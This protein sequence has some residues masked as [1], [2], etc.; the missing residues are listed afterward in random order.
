VNEIPSSIKA[1]SEPQVN[2][3]PPEV[4]ARRA[5][6][7]QRSAVFFVFVLFLAALG[8][9]VYWAGSQEAAAKDDLQAAQDRGAELAAQIAQYDY[10]VA[11]QLELLNAENAK[12]YVGSTEIDYVTLINGMIEALPDG[13]TFD[14]L[15]WTVMSVDS[16]DP[17]VTVLDPFTVPDL[18]S[19]VI[20]GGLPFYVTAAD[21][22]EALNGV[23]GLERTRIT[24]IQSQEDSEGGEHFLFEGTARVNALALSGRFSS[25]WNENHAMVQAWS[26]VVERVQAATSAVAAAEAAESAGAPGAE[27]ELAEARAALDI[28]TRDNDQVLAFVEAIADLQRRVALLAEGVAYGM[29]GAAQDLEGALAEFSEM[30]AVAIDLAAAINEWDEE[31]SNLATVEA[32][33]EAAEDYLESCQERVD[34]LQADV[35]LGVE[36]ASEALEE[37]EVWLARAEYDLALEQ[38]SLEGAAGKIGAEEAEATTRAALDAVLLEIA[39]FIDVDVDVDV[40]G[41]EGGES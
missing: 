19:L 11:M 17:L 12:T 25:A 28:A 32:R 37:A 1:P 7:R 39:V 3:L 2:L 4:E 14:Q 34:T 31:A 20:R 27:E 24:M 29:E 6:G 33:I 41:E 5:R 10:V 22:E 8:F 35:G 40:D 26:A 38:Q 13:T 18:G 21:L 16:T 15:T 9:G 30:W 36:G 23:T